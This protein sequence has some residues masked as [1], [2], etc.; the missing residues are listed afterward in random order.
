MVALG[1]SVVLGMGLFGLLV[2]ILLVLAITAQ[3]IRRVFDRAPNLINARLVAT[4]SLSS[5]VCVE[6]RGAPSLAFEPA[7]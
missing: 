2:V 4:G 1:M 7:S 3:G 6:G 5:V